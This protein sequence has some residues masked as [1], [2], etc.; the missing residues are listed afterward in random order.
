MLSWSFRYT[1]CTVETRDL[2][3]GTYKFEVWG[4]S[5][6]T[7]KGLGGAGGYSSGIIEIN[8]NT[9]AFIHVGSQGSD[10]SSGKT[11]AG[12]NGGGYATH[13]GAR[14][15]GG[16]T[17][18]RLVSDSLYSRVIVAGGG[19]GGT[20][21][22]TVEFGGFGGG[23]KGGDGGNDHVQAGKGASQDGET[24]KCA[25]NSATTC[26]KGIFG[27]GGNA[28]NDFAGGAGG[29]WYGG[30]ASYQEEGG[31]GGSGYVWTSS[32]PKVSQYLLGSEYY[33]TDPVLIDGSHSF[34]CPDKTKNETGH[35][36]NGYAII[37][38]IEVLPDPPVIPSV[39]SFSFQGE[40]NVE[41]IKDKN[42]IFFL[43]EQDNYKTIAGPGKYKFNLNGSY[44]GYSIFADFSITRPKTMEI[45][46]G[47]DAFVIVDDKTVLLA[48]GFLSDTPVYIHPKSKSILSYQ[49]SL[50]KCSRKD[51]ATVTIGYTPYI[52]K[53]THK[54]KTISMNCFI[55][56]FLLVT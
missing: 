8:K 10:S 36:G 2:V 53:N 47:K 51:L 31:G 16:A 40:K 11:T 37:T 5:G 34:P 30:S 13:S 15:G 1:D 41:N 42:S 48:P 54:R 22:A 46:I 32:S 39:V 45:K 44:C 18:I 17:D 52:C 38:Q 21:D 27:Y 12:C 23:E 7:H 19:G 28:T 29:G 25:D 26:P 35:R 55:N 56:I 14:S 9:K 4:A 3:P 49:M 24:T 50:F 6:G 20:A 33:L 43:K